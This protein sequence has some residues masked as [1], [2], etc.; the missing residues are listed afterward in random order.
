MTVFFEKKWDGMFRPGIH[1][2]TLVELLIVIAIIA[3]LAGMLLPALNKAR[4]KARA[5]S[6]VSQ[7][8]QIGVAFSL[9]GNDYNGFY[10]AW[11]TYADALDGGAYIEGDTWHQGLILLG[12]A[13]PMIF[14]CYPKN[15]LTGPSYAPI[16]T[17]TGKTTAYIGY[18]YNYGGIG[19]AAL[20]NGAN[21]KYCRPANVK[22]LRKP[23]KVYIIMDT[24]RKIA[25]GIVGNHQL[26]WGE[27]WSVGVPDGI[28]HNGPVNIL[29]G[30]GR[31]EA[32]KILNPEHPYYT[33]KAWADSS[34]KRF[35][36]WTGGRGANE[37]D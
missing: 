37:D 1:F 31:V 2:F 15:A 14:V 25:A 33:L 17:V 12:Y 28:R 20:F 3:I 5:I 24:V 21:A 22:E 4:E 16:S 9:Y 19:G 36:C 32:I 27:D 29:F 23:S 30:D 18:G 35:S 13:K 6:C 26:Y 7:Q 10:P 34:G 8:K 11:R